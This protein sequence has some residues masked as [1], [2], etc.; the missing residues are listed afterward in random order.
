MTH[1]CGVLNIR[2][3]ISE[4]IVDQLEKLEEKKKQFQSLNEQLR[5]QLHQNEAHIYSL[6]GA[7]QALEQ[8]NQKFPKK[9]LDES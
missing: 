6:T 7:I 2:M 8:L 4:Y 1:S 5:N 3:I 9:N